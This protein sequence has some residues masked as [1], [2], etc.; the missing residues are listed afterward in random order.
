MA[1]APGHF[2][3]LFKKIAILTFVQ[4]PID[5]AIKSADEASPVR[6]Q[7]I[8]RLR[9]R[10]VLVVTRINTVVLGK[11]G[12]VPDVL[13]MVSQSIPSIHL[14]KMLSNQDVDSEPPAEDPI[15]RVQRIGFVRPAGQKA[16]D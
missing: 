16:E 12:R 14:I 10:W 3:Q 9:K 6:N 11:T 1:I 13:V 4:R 2:F 5:P 15:P 8:H 7:T